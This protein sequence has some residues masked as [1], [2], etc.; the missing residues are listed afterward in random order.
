MQQD[1]GSAGVERAE[2][3]AHGLDK[4]MGTLQGGT[5]VDPGPQEV[6]AEGSLW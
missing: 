4:A 2:E 1:H 3:Q 6:G 5:A